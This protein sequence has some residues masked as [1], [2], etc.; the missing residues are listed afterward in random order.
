MKRQSE[1]SQPSESDF[2]PSVQFSPALDRPALRHSLTHL[3]LPPIRPP[4]RKEHTV[5]VTKSSLQ[6]RASLRKFAH[7]QP[8]KRK[9]SLLAMLSTTIVYQSDIPVNPREWKQEQL[10]GKVQNLLNRSFQA[11]KRMEHLGTTI[12]S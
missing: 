2:R 4:H 11:K 5:I 1:N 8:I 9:N 6:Y 7:L 12:G 10:V 3:A